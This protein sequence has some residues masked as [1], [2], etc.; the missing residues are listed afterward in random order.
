MPQDS[1][2]PPALAKSCAAQLHKVQQ[3][4]ETI[5]KSSGPNGRAD[6]VVPLLLMQC[7][8]AGAGLPEQ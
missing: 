8:Q 1:L 2:L 3:V 7:Q 4:S 5:T 6:E